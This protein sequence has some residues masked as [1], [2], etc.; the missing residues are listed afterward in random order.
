MPVLTVKYQCSIC[1]KYITSYES[2]F[3]PICQEII[4]YDCSKPEP[5]LYK[6]FRCGKIY[7]VKDAR[8]SFTEC[9][10]CY[11]CYY[12][13][14][15]LKIKYLNERYVF[16][17]PHCL[18]NS[19]NQEPILTSDSKAGLIR[20]A[21]TILRNERLNEEH[22]VY[23]PKCKS[24]LVNTKNNVVN[25][26]TRVF[27]K[28]IFNAKSIP[29]NTRVDLTYLIKNTRPEGAFFR[30]DWE[31]SGN[32]QIMQVSRAAEFDFH[33]PFIKSQKTG[34]LVVKADSIGELDIYAD[35]SYRFDEISYGSGK[36][37]I[38]VGPIIVYPKVEINRILEL[39]FTMDKE[40]NVRIH[41]KNESGQEIQRLIISDMILEGA[42]DFKRK[43]WDIRNL[44][45]GVELEYTYSFRNDPN[46]S[47]VK[48][49]MLRGKIRFANF[50]PQ[51][52]LDY[53]GS[54]E[55]V[56]IV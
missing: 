15:D 36:T 54:T 33:S 13:E 30:I 38:K 46:I 34:K 37:K 9:R 50:M 39:P 20:N 29:A 55:I 28:I 6:C 31:P 51:I 49:D 27:P 44:Q 12:C 32:I 3:C 2:Y 16:E 53:T 45:P 5:V 43:Y 18:W 4:C 14:S 22:I 10:D 23:C 26:L 47:K 40:N 7:G 42:L 11:E 17:C 52:F 24:T 1:E 25:T 35:L 56:E 19:E 8:E 21:S 48:F 41:V